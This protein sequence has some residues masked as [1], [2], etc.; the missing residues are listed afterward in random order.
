MF[1]NSIKAAYETGKVQVCLPGKRVIIDA[2][3]INK[4]KA[5][6]LTS[7]DR[8][9]LAKAVKARCSKCRNCGAALPADSIQGDGWHR[10][11]AGCYPK[12]ALPTDVDKSIEI[13]IRID[14]RSF[15][16][17]PIMSNDGLLA[18]RVLPNIESYV[19]TQDGEVR[20][21]PDSFVMPEGLPAEVA[22]KIERSFILT[23]RR[24]DEARAIF[25][26]YNAN[27][28]EVIDSFP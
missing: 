11:C 16:V 6:F 17:F 4:L 1:Y 7:H 22:E 3:G 8:Q 26:A 19:L 10:Q 15:R 2:Y 27:E 21:R 25:E 18:M 12:E 28:F 9:R 14:G 24:A 23:D 13:G 5:F 20:M